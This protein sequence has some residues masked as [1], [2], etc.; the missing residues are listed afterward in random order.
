MFF[1]SWLSL[2]LDFWKTVAFLH[3]V[4]LWSQV[5]SREAEFHPTFLPPVLV[6]KSSCVPELCRCFSIPVTWQGFTSA[7]IAFSSGFAWCPCNPSQTREEQHSS[8]PSTNKAGPSGD[9]SGIL[10]LT[11]GCTG[12]SL[13]I[14]WLLDSLGCLAV[15]YPSHC[16]SFLRGT[17]L[18]GILKSG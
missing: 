16:H 7:C 10:L 9:L 4:R 18:N 12:N 6:L 2:S 1:C 17:M 11:S 5:A 13:F 8:I 3:S 15:V 14:F